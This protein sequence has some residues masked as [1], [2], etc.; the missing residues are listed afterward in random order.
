MIYRLNR[1][2][3]LP[4]S[5]T[6]AWEFFSNPANLALITPPSLDFR[7]IS[8]TGQSMYPGQ[9]IVYTVCPIP[10]IKQRW[11][12]EITHVDKLHYFVD[13]QRY[14]PYKMWHHQH[15]FRE[16]EGGILVEDIVDYIVPFGPLG[17]LAH[18]L[19]IKPTLDKIFLFRERALCER[20]GCY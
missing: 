6:E 5:I 8:N 1:E 7:I 19:F 14:G 3:K 11:V 9:I 2:I 10:F 20:F 17:V 13:E 16:I 4:I 15:L 12:T 18:G